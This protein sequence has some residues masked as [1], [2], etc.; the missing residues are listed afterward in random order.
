M[1]E[2]TYDELMRIYAREKGPSFSALP[3]NFYQLAGK[4]LSSY[5][6]S[7]PAGMREY[8]NAYKMIKFIYQRRLEKIFN[9]LA[10]YN[11]G[12]ELPPEMLFKEKELYDEIIP[13]IKRFENDIDN[14]LVCV[15]KPDCVVSNSNS[16]L[17]ERSDKLKVLILKDVDEFIGAS[18]SVVGPFKQNSEVELNQQ[19]AE[20]L[21]EIGSAKRID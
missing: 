21:I 12:V 20:I 5:D 13:I 16:I 2:L 1:D 14:E 15:D 3:P 4:L 7:N 6:K 17:R 11:K 19:D 9:Y 8:N 18:G 10:S